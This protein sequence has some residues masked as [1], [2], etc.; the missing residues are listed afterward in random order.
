MA[1]ISSSQTVSL[2]SE[3]RDALYDHI[4]GD[5]TGRLCSCMGPEELLDLRDRMNRNGAIFDRIGWDEKGDGCTLVV[6]ETLR[7]AVADIRRDVELT[8]ENSLSSGPAY[9][10][11]LDRAALAAID[12]I[13]AA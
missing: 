10:V 11:A 12:A 7:A 9:L 13:E 6:D 8:L 4:R 1:T 5:I 2:T 3:Q